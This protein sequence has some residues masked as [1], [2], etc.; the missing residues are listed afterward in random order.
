MNNRSV[1]KYFVFRIYFTGIMIYLFLVISVWFFIFIK[2]TPNLMLSI[3][4][5]LSE[6][7][8]LEFQK[9]INNKVDDLHKNFDSQL[10]LVIHKTKKS[11]GEFVQDLII[12]SSLL[13]G[14]FLTF[15]FN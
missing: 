6:S 11:T 13:L 5:S 9:R 10:S 7:V 12:L 4:S 3:S 1:P 14:L 2:N 8:K 15:I